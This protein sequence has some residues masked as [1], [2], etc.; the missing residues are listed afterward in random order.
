MEC[1]YKLRSFGIPTEFIPRSFTGSIKNNYHKTFLKTRLV[2]DKHR[3]AE[4]S[5]DYRQYYSSNSDAKPFPGIECPEVNCFLVRKNGVV[6]NNP[7]NIEFRYL[8][9]EKENEN[10]RLQ[11]EYINSIA[12]E[13]T[14][15]NIQI[16]IFDENNLWYTKATKEE[17]IRKHVLQVMRD[18]RKRKNV[19]KNQPQSIKCF[20]NKFQE[21]DGQTFKGDGCRVNN[22]CKDEDQ[23][24]KD[25]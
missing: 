14:A 10:K 23:E 6:W 20:T 16:L 5:G 11:E 7:G 12:E 19:L 9:E 3:K 4:A 22:V 25:G 24:M 17:D 15:R 18:I 1:D 13:I 21:L 8:L 2:M